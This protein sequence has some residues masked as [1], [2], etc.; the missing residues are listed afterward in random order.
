MLGNLGTTQLSPKHIWENVDNP[1]EFLDEEAVIGCGPY[2]LTDYSKGHG[3]YRFEAFK[4][5]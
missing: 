2:I 4:D 1:K 3:T 5:Y